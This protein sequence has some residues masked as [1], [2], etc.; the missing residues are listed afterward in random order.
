[1][2]DDMNIAKMVGVPNHFVDKLT[3][4]ITFRLDHHSIA[5]FQAIG[6]EIGLPA[7][8]VMNLFLRNIAYTRYSIPIEGPKGIAE[9]RLPIDPE[10]HR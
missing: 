3:K 8:R 6:D 5:Y 4:E 1:M 7:E 9:A 2:C 10:M